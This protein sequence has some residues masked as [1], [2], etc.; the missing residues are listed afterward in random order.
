MIHG[1]IMPVLP[2]APPCV[3]VD[4]QERART[5]QWRGWKHKPDTPQTMEA[6][7]NKTVTRLAT[8]ASNIQ[9][10]ESVGC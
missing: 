5:K 1:D 7:Q 6:G 8:Q 9:T 4:P 10:M 2:S 3:F